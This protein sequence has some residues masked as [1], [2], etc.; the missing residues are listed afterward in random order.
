MAYGT[1]SHL[2][3]PPNKVPKSIKQ[4][5]QD[6]TVQNLNLTTQDISKGN[7]IDFLLSQK[8]PA[9]ALRKIL[10]NI[11]SKARKKYNTT[12]CKSEWIKKKL[13]KI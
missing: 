11:I 8:C 6:V 3:P 12:S 2:D 1:H 9:L 7:G 5:I 4:K 13:K 10:A